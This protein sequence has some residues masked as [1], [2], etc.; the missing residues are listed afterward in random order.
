MLARTRHCHVEQPAQLK[1]DLYKYTVSRT[2]LDASAQMNIPLLPEVLLGQDTFAEPEMP[3]A[4][5]GV[6]RYVWHSRFEAMLLEIKDGVA[7]VNGQAVEPM[8]ETRGNGPSACR[9]VV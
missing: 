4:T 2:T 6:Q 7:Y 3:L 1:G 5:E 8:R 9:D